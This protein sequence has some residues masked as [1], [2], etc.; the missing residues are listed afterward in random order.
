MTNQSV[1]P[2]HVVMLSNSYKPW[3]RGG[4][5]THV[6]GLAEALTRYCDVTVVN[7][8]NPA[9]PFE[10]E[11]TIYDGVRVIRVP[12]QY[13]VTDPV[14]HQVLAN[15]YYLLGTLV[16]LKSK[17]VD[18]LH[19]HEGV[20]GLA[21]LGLKHVLN[22]PLVTTLHYGQ[23][24]AQE[25]PPIADIKRD[26][27]NSSDIVVAVS[28]S[29]QAEA[30]A[31]GFT[32]EVRYIPNGVKR[33]EYMPPSNKKRSTILFVGR[34]VR[35]KGIGVLIEA[36]AHLKR[37]GHLISLEIAG[38][39]PTEQEE[40]LGEAERVGLSTADITL[41]G[42]IPHEELQRHYERATLVV[43]PS[44]Y[45]AFGLVALEAMSFGR[46][47]IASNI[48]GLSEVVTDGATGLL[49]QPGDAQGLAIAIAELITDPERATEMGMNAY[50]YSLSHTWDTTAAT[51]HELYKEL[52][53]K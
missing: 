53:R 27:L 25:L 37:T 31:L 36:V 12:C 24:P 17:P 33:G 38:G 35:Y 32:R 1:L 9:L 28:R 49:V 8:G 7:W 5:G 21:A 29:L 48:G 13:Q 34:L 22:I 42:W 3:T 30:P 4:I 44:L 19:A 52:V 26:L 11:V 6:A 23:S 50:E 15:L 20:V 16:A 45:E 46:P 18:I 2:M 41:L 40:L 39:T 51:T 10:D 43:V 14:A 47:V